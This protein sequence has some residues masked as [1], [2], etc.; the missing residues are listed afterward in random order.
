MTI[1]APKT[2]VPEHEAH[3]VPA[4]IVQAYPR[5]RKYRGTPTDD[6]IVDHV[7]SRQHLSQEVVDRP[8]L[9]TRAVSSEQVTADVAKPPLHRMPQ[10]VIA[11]T[12][13]TSNLLGGEHPK[14]AGYSPLK[15]SA[16]VD[17]TPPVRSSVSHFT[18]CPQRLHVE[19]WMLS[20]A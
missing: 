20:T 12:T 16:P 15:E 14:T 2:C 11:P 17:I 13:P 5:E 18:V 1:S 6:I 9:E 3:V 4:T 10:D 19:I 8:T 7:S